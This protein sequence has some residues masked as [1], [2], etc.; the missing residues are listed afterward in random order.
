M[1]NFLN[2][3]IEQLTKLSLLKLEILNNVIDS[4]KTMIVEAIEDQTE[5]IDVYSNVNQ[6]HFNKIDEIDSQ[7]TTSIQTLDINEMAIVDNILFPIKKSQQTALFEITDLNNKTILKVNNAFSEVKDQLAMIKEKKN[8]NK[9]YSSYDTVQT[10][11]IMD[12][13]ESGL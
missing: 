7:I 9:G 8:I 3:K 2:I 6:D 13:K 1:N 4:M 5:S 12:F 11:T 10:G